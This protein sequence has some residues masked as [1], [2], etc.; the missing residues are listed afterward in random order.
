MAAVR[1]QQCEA[2][3]LLTIQTLQHASKGTE[4]SGRGGAV[5]TSPVRAQFRDIEISDDDDDDDD[6]GNDFDNVKHRRHDSPASE[7]GAMAEVEMSSLG[8]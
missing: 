8:E 6:D 4:R 5:P 1:L 7:F 2:L 3:V